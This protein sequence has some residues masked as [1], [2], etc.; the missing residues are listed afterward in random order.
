MLTPITWFTE[1]LPVLRT[2]IVVA[3][4]IGFAIFFIFSYFLSTYITKPINKLTDTMRKAGEEMVTLE[5][6]T[7][8]APNEINELNQTYNQLAEQTNY[9]IQMVYEK[10][11]VKSR[12]ELKEIGRA[13]C[14]E[15]V[16]K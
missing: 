11:L 12:T 10:E 15:R 14:R 5:P 1:G 16:K 9:L 13:S 8:A 7:T 4:L 6:S 2:I 3:G